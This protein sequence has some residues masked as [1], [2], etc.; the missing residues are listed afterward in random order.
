MLI[1]FVLAQLLKKLQELPSLQK[2]YQ[3]VEN[4]NAL[5]NLIL[6]QRS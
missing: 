1:V 2:Q 6:I 5:K 4:V 3:Q